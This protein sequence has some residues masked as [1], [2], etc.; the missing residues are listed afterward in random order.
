MPAQ[1]THYLHGKKVLETL[2]LKID[3]EAFF[4]GTQ[5]PDFFFFHQYYNPFNKNVLRKLGH[6][7]HEVSPVKLMCLMQKLSK[8]S[9]KLHS[10]FLGFVCH[11]SLD[12]I[13]HP[14]INEKA[15][16]MMDDLQDQSICHSEIESNIDLCLRE[17]EKFNI[18]NIVPKD[19]TFYIELADMFKIILKELLNQ[20]VTKEKLIQ[21]FKD[22]RIM[23]AIL[24][25]S[26]SIKRKIM[27]KIEKNK[28]HTLS[29]HLIPIKKVERDFTLAGKTKTFDELFKLALKRANL[30]V[31]G[32]DKEKFTQITNNE[33][34]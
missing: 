6:D 28:A 23:F 8:K 30:L 9:H 22:C 26:K 25:D 18:K 29:C 3:K 5:G 19:K 4:F 1:I 13:C 12:S 20:E 24:N 7:L 10:Y 15:K 27:D 17:N 14:Y 31:D 21:T 34:F 16:E 11:Y 33:S 2:S 32:F